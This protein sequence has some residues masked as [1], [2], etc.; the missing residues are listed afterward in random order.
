[1]KK[2]YEYDILIIIYYYVKHLICKILNIYK[3]II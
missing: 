1:M 2:K 3:Y